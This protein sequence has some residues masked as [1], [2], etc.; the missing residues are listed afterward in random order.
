MASFARRFWERCGMIISLQS[1]LKCDWLIQ[2]CLD[3]E[4]LIELLKLL[5][6]VEISVRCLFKGD[7]FGLLVRLIVSLLSLYS[8]SSELN[9]ALACN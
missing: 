9:F 7:Q 8:Y 5:T 1:L 4:G 3:Q 2:E 6:Y